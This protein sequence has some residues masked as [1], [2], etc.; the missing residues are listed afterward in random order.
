MP[1]TPAFSLAIHGGAGTI[2]RDAMTPER[3]ASYTEALHEAIRAGGAVLG[4]GGLALDAVEA[5]VR[6]ME[7]CPLFNAGRGAVFTADGTHEMDACIMEGRDRAAGAVAGVHGVANPIHLARLVLSESEHVLLAGAGAM[8]FAADQ[9]IPLHDAAYFHD[10]LRYRQWQSVRGTDRAQLDHSDLIE[11]NE[12]PSGKKGDHDEGALN[13]KKF[14]TVG[15]VARDAHGN[16]AAATSTGGMTNKR[17]GRVG[18]SPIIGAG[19]YADNRTC[20]VSCT[21]SGEFF[22]RGVVAYDVACLMAYQN[23]GLADAAK[24]AIHEHLGGLQGDGGLIAVDG[25]GGI[26]MPFNTP[27]MYRGSLQAGH[28]PVVRIYGD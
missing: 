20:A 1:A 25:L 15:A 3:E 23:L 7:D 18:D 26:A 12:D 13:E 24:K 5:A 21:G 14:G 16:L 27:G 9:G 6:S 17:Y 11:D 10:D 4:K 22:M 19:N 8:A 2:R 28:A